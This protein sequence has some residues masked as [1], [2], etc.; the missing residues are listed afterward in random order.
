MAQRSPEN[1]LVFLAYEAVILLP[2]TMLSL[3]LTASGKL[4][5]CQL[6]LPGI[7]DLLFEHLQSIQLQC[8][9]KN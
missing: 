3:R 2:C 7:A 5:D 1:I 6:E 9:H 8:T 4:K